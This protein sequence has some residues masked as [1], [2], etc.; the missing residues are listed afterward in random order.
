MKKKKHAFEERTVRTL[1]WKMVVKE[2]EWLSNG[3]RLDVKERILKNMNMWS[4]N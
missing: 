2:E 4:H 1:N 3:R